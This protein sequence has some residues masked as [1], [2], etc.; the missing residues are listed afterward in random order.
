MRPASTAPH[1]SPCSNRVPVLIR[2]RVGDAANITRL[3]FARAQKR[4]ND[5]ATRFSLSGHDAAQPPIS[6]MNISN[7]HGVNQHG[8][9]NTRDRVRARR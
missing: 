1:E 7:A 5:A 2:S 3:M 4:A 8:P 6:R 9:R